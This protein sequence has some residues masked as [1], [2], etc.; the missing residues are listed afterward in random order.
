MEADSW[1]RPPH[2]QLPGSEKLHTNVQL[3]TGSS[4]KLKLTGRTAVE[5]CNSAEVMAAAAAC[6]PRLQPGLKRTSLVARRTVQP[7]RG[8]DALLA[9]RIRPS[10][11]RRFVQLQ[12]LAQAHAPSAPRMHD[13]IEYPCDGLA[14]EKLKNQGAQS[15]LPEPTSP[16]RKIKGNLSVPLRLQYTTLDQLSGSL[17]TAG[18][19]YKA[20]SSSGNL[21]VMKTLQMQ[22]V[23]S[24]QQ[25]EQLENEAETL[26]RLNHL[27]I[28]AC[29]EY[30]EHMQ[31]FCV[32]QEYVEGKHLT[33][34]LDMGWQPSHSEV[35]RIAAELLAI[36]AY[37]H[38]HQVVHSAIQPEHIMLKGG[39]SGGPVVVVG[40]GSAVSFSLDTHSPTEPVW[41]DSPNN[42]QAA[43]TLLHQDAIACA[44]SDM[45][46]LGCVLRFLLQGTS[47][48]DRTTPY[49]SQVNLDS[50]LE[51]LVHALLQD[52]WQQRPSAQQALQML[53]E[54]HDKNTPDLSSQ[55]TAVPPSVPTQP[56]GTDRP[57][58]ASQAVK[59]PADSTV[60]SASAVAVKKYGNLQEG[61]QELQAVVSAVQALLACAESDSSAA[62]L[63]PA[64]PS[65]PHVQPSQE[66]RTLLALGLQAASNGAQLLAQH[67]NMTANA[68]P[69]ARAL[70]PNLT[71]PSAAQFSTCTGE[72]LGSNRIP[73][74]HP[75]Q[76]FVES[77]VDKLF[78]LALA[79]MV[80]PLFY[81]GGRFVLVTFARA[82]AGRG[83]VVRMDYL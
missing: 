76:L 75:L 57:L 40:F 53:T 55:G 81:V 12:L 70:E 4:S 14:G 13:R 21:V 74:P 7:L 50:P 71:K 79:M 24:W 18:T 8:A 5:P 52:K 56:P 37:L 48:D 19:L 45:F 9:L 51:Q 2:G 61:Q 20:Y 80:I 31:G 83:Q 42:A 73:D 82:F 49:S 77:M 60:G 26:K 30:G 23:A 78:W 29:L 64:I 16:K 1:S 11:G 44:A 66:G 43:A 28:P 36:L 35:Q 6:S 41:P 47:Y 17:S 72:P 63:G 54:P 39:C 58:G 38:Q 68:Y 46:S 27:G 69:Q 59:S 10:K 33:Q 32:V 25:L 34:M 22:E 15:S 65:G 3:H 62:Q 67:Q